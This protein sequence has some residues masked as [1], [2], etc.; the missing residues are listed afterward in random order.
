MTYPALVVI[1]DGALTGIGSEIG[2]APLHPRQPS[3]SLLISECAAHGLVV[4]LERLQ[5]DQLRLL[6]PIC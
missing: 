5:N 2:P 3:I 6:L 4:M 1:I